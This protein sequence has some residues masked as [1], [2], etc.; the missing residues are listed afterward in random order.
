M[1]KCLQIVDDGPS[2]RKVQVQLASD[3]WQDEIRITNGGERNKVR[4]V[5]KRVG[6]LMCNRNAETRLANPTCPDQRDK[7]GR[8]ILQKGCDSLDVMF[9]ADNCSQWIRESQLR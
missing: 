1:Q 9:T 5:R 3:E 6:H 8:R 7:S 2:A 4:S